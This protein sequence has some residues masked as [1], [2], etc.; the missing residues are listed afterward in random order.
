[1]LQ[2][3]AV[4]CIR[5]QCPALFQGSRHTQIENTLQCVAVC[6]GKLQFIAMCYN[7]LQCAAVFCSGLQCVATR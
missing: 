7:E 1:V 5:L 3:F 6:F 4:G 2:Y